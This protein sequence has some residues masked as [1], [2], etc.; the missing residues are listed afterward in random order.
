VGKMEAFNP[1]RALLESLGDMEYITAFAAKLPYA[2]LDNVGVLGVNFEGM[3]G[4]LYQMKN[5][6]AKAVV[7]LDGWEGKVGSM[8]ILTNS[9]YYD[10]GNIAVPYFAVMQDEKEPQTYLALSQAVYDSLLYADRYYYVLNGMSH[11]YLI[12]SLYIVP[13]LPPEK[14]QAYRFLYESI[15]HFFDAYIKDKSESAGYLKKPLVEKNIPTS[16]V[17]LELKKPALPGA[18]GFDDIQKLLVAGQT[19]KAITLI[20]QTRQLNAGAKIASGDMINNWGYDLLRN[21]KFADAIALFTLNTEFY[22][23]NAGWFDSLAEGYETAGDNINMKKA[24]QRVLN[25]LAN[26]TTLSTGE[27]SLKQLAERRMKD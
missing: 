22:P 2:D 23:G 12:T 4:L 25:L 7:S 15:G 21:K 17:K 24:S 18:P 13:N 3:T 9:L 10:A 27:V 26:K 16:V 11:V 19:A 8:H 6:Q 14:K 1:Q 20:K 5:Q